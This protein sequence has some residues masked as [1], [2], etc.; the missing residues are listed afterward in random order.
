MIKK[1]F[2]DEL[3]ICPEE[4]FPTPTH[5]ITTETPLRKHEKK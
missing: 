4:N 5:M 3:N 1:C 2:S